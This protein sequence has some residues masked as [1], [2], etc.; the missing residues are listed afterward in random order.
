MF[1]TINAINASQMMLV[2][3]RSLGL[4]DGQTKTLIATGIRWYRLTF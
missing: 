3:T 4:T 2:Y 1:G